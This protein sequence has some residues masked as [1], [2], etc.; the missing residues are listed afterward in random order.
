MANTAATLLSQIAT[1]TA[2]RD[3]YKSG[4]AELSFKLREANQSVDDLSEALV[5]AA[6]VNTMNSDSGLIYYQAKIAGLEH[7][8]EELEKEVDLLQ[9]RC[10]KLR[11]VQATMQ[12]KASA[13]TKGSVKQP[14]A[15]TA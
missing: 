15:G 4:F 13:R 5:R 12:E 1:L 7:L 6:N 2:E 11:E 9:E 10:E 3:F 8:N 14:W